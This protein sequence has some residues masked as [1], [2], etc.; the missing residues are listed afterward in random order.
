[1]ATPI[2]RI[3][4]DLRS[5]DKAHFFEGKEHATK[6]MEVKGKTVP[7][8]PLYADL[9]LWDSGK[10]SDYG[11]D[12]YLSQDVSKEARERGEK[13]PIVGN[14]KP[15]K[16]KTE[17]RPTPPPATGSNDATDEDPFAF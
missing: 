9:T 10:V 15:I 13:G 6:T 7:Y 14:S 2:K 3:K 17:T 8:R 5:L 12:G 16:A 1:M 11:D 4:I